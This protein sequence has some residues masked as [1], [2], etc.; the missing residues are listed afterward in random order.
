VLAPLESILTKRRQYL[1]LPS[2]M[3]LSQLNISF[4][5]FKLGSSYFRARSNTTRC[6]WSVRFDFFIICMDMI[7]IVPLVRSKR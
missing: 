2:L 5:L 1:L 6:R 4:V 7:W 3:Y